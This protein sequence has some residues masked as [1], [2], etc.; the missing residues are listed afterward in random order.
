MAG[1]TGEARRFCGWK[2]AA[3]LHPFRLAV[4]F[5]CTARKAERAVHPHPFRFDASCRRP[6]RRRTRLCAVRRLKLK[7]KFY[8]LQKRNEIVTVFFFFFDVDLIEA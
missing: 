7:L 4:A 5:L 1:R 6:F 3:R 8:I 2:H